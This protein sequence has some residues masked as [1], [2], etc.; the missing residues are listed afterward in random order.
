MKPSFT[1][2]TRI[3]VAGALT[4]KT[5]RRAQDGPGGILMWAV[6]LR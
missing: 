4:E 6:M 2:V 3:P 1:V 5:C